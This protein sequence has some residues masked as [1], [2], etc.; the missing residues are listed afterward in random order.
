MNMAARAKQARADQADIDETEIERAAYAKRQ[1]EIDEAWKA[2]ESTDP[3]G[4]KE[5]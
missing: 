3:D 2:R 4:V 1:Q 5:E